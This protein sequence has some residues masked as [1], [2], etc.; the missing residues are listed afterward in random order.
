MKGQRR[1]F[2]RPTGV[3]A[4]ESLVFVKSFYDLVTLRERRP[5][6]DT[7]SHGYPSDVFT[8]SKSTRLTNAILCENFVFR[9]VTI[10]YEHL[11]PVTLKNLEQKLGFSGKNCFVRRILLFLS[12]L[13]C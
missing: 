3:R 4:R 9:I 12:R 10:S 5:Y 6:S 1:L 2:R 13:N 7:F 8:Q 11:A